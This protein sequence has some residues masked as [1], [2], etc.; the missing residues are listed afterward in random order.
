LKCSLEDLIGDCILKVSMKVVCE[1]MTKS[2]CIDEAMEEGVG[3]SISKVGV[4]CMD[5]RVEEKGPLYVV[6]CT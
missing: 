3:R 5:S 6:K 2:S 4:P 1:G